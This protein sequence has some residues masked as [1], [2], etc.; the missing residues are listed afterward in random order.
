M[1]PASDGQL[2]DSAHL[3]QDINI[4]QQDTTESDAPEQA[5]GGASSNARQQVPSISPI[6]DYAEETGLGGASG[7]DTADPEES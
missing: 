6:D 7:P 5:V 4:P 1:N 2:P 3:R